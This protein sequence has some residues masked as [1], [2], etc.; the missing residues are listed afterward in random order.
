MSTVTSHLSHPPQYYLSLP[1]PPHPTSSPP[2][3]ISLLVS[4]W[5]ENNDVTSGAITAWN[6]AGQP[7]EQ[8]QGGYKALS[9][10]PEG[11]KGRREGGIGGNK[12]GRKA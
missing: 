10:G 8:G 9:L 11:G 3:R 2:S 6:N 12:E 7:R 1:P 4:W 5:E